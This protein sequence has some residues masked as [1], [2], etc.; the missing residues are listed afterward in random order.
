M[1][2]LELFPAEAQRTDLLRL[3]CFPHAGG[4]TSAFYRWRKVSG[5]ELS[6]IPAR[7]P[8]REARLNEPPVDSMSELA[9]TVAETI[10]NLPAGPFALLGYSVGAHLAHQVAR[11]LPRIG[12]RAPQAL[13]VVASNAPGTPA[14]AAAME[15]SPVEDLSDDQLVEHMHRKYG[16]IPA[17]VRNDPSWLAAIVPALRADL[18][19]LRAQS[20]DIYEP[21]QCPVLA[22]GGLDDSYITAAGLAGW[23]SVTRGRLTTR[24]YPGGH[25]FL[26]QDFNASTPGAAGRL[27][28]GSSGALADVLGFA[29]HGE[30]RRD[31][32]KTRG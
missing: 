22:V 11:R 7:L 5:N 6:V 17:V 26:Y 30:L 4:G 3:F 8:G 12:E 9:E 31:Q 18:K 10:S 29:Q 28:S 32:E 1:I 2:D 14:H 20:F 27:T 24:Q 15:A 13:V 23:Q 19:L 16:G 25:F 21:L